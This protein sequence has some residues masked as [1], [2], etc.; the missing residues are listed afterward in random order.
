MGVSRPLSAPE[1][2]TSR[3]QIASFDCGDQALNDWL[4][5]RALSNQIA[6]ASLTF[7]VCEND[8]VLGYY[9]LATGAIERALTP[10]SIRRNMP[11]PI[12]VIV[13]GRLAVD[14]TTQSKG[15]GRA[16]LRDAMWRV[17]RVSGDVAVR[18]LVVNALG[19]RIVPFYQSLGFVASP[20][21]PRLLF[22]PIQTIIAAIGQPE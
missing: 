3:H 15:L 5:S 17:M 10:G 13:L 2:L 21:D 16:L 8:I 12:P 6:H 1:P 14:Q 9:S 18:A 7:V 11:D 4:R 19:D 20:D 22:M